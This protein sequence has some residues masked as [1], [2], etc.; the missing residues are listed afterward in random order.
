MGFDWVMV[1]EIANLRE[2]GLNNLIKHYILI[3]SHKIF[4]N[5]DSSNFSL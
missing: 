3:R 4:K 1:F 5:A 2:N